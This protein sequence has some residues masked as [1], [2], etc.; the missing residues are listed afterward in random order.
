VTWDSA[1]EVAVQESITDIQK[2]LAE[3]ETYADFSW[4]VTRHTFVSNVNYA[5]WLFVTETGKLPL[6][7]SK[8]SRRAGAFLFWGIVYAYRGASIPIVQPSIVKRNAVI[9]PGLPHNHSE[10][11]MAFCSRK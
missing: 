6:S 10:I 9:G 1:S 3:D 7:L 11:G 8:G 4:T 5:P 2:A